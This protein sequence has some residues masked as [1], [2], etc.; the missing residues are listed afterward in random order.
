MIDKGSSRH[1]SLDHLEK[2]FRKY[3]D[4]QAVY[5]FGSKASG[6]S[7][8]ESDLD[9]AILPRGSSLR[10]QKLDLLADLAREGFSNVDM[11]FLD[12]KDV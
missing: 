9:L 11:V 8:A 1:P 6:K 3:Q 12:T 2:V 7:H 10:N 5:L 4:I